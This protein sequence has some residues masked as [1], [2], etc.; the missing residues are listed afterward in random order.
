MSDPADTQ[1]RSHPV[2]AR[3]L[4][5]PVSALM[6][7]VLVVVLGFVS[8]RRIPIMLMPRGISN[9]ELT[10]HASY[11][12]ASP[13]EVLDRVTRPLED[14]I[15]SLPD[16]LQVS[17][18][19]SASSCRIH[20]LCARNADLDLTY[21]ELSDRLEHTKAS[22][23]NEV[24]DLR[25][26]RHNP[27]METPIFWL[28]FN[29]DQ[30]VEDPSGTVD[31]LIQ[32]RLEAVD[33]V[34]QVRVFGIVLE[35]VRLF[36]KPR[37]LRSHGLSLYELV[38]MLRKDNFVLP[39]GGVRDG[40]REYLLRIDA[41]FRSL[42]EIREYPL[43]G[44]LQLQDVADVVVSNAYRDQVSRTNG[45]NSMMAII[46]K[47]SDEN[48]VDV[49]RRVLSQIR[50]LKDDPRLRGFTIEVYF[51]QAN[52]ILSALDNLKGS[53]GWG[54]L[55]AVVILYLFV[56]RAL[57]TLLVALAIPVSLLTALVAI[58][59]SGFSFNL[60]SLAGFTLA[61]GM[62]V[63]N[64]VVVAEN[65]ARC[66][67]GGASLF[68]AAATGAGQV[69]L[70][71]MLSTLTTIIVFTPL[72]FMAE[73]QNTRVLLRE[74][75][76]PITYSLLASLVTAL[77]LLPIAIVQFGGGRVRA[78]PPT[79]D[80]RGGRLIGAYQRLLSF[81][82]RH[83][84]GMVLITLFIVALGLEAAR[85]LEVSFAQG[86][87]DTSLQI[88]VTLP[89]R[90][91]LPEASGVFVKL[92]SFLLSRTADYGFRNLSVNFDRRGGQVYLWSSPE[93][94]QLDKP[95]MARRL[96]QELP[97]IP[98]VRYQIGF[99]R[100]DTQEGSIH[101][102][103]EGPDSENLA[104]IAEDVVREL[105]RLPD[106]AH[107]RSD[108]DAGNDE[109]RVSILS[110]RARRYGISHETL[111]GLISWGVGGQELSG[112]LGGPREIPI[113]IE[114]EKSEAGDL[115][116]VRELDVPVDGRSGSVPLGALARFEFNRSLGSIRRLNGVT[117]LGV[118][119]ETY[120]RNSYRINRAVRDVLSN[121][122]F[123]EGYR[124]R[125]SGGREQ[126]EKGSEEI[127]TG[128]IVG[129][130]FVFLLMG[131]L[132]EAVL[133]PLAVIL[134]I[135]LALA[136][137]NLA[138]FVTGTPLDGMA[139]LAFILL[140]G[141]VVNNGIVLVDRIRQIRDSG[142]PRLEAILTGCGQRLRPVLMTALTTM[143]G[144]LPMAL[145]RIFAAGASS[146][147]NYQSLAIATL[148]GLT[149]STLM[150]VFVVP[151]FYTLFDDLGRI[152]ARLFG[153]TGFGWTETSRGSRLPPP[154]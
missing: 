102:Q 140:A 39:A 74:L 9:S 121:F 127:L 125:D 49:S 117:S 106:L 109:L 30:A 28:G 116:Y 146:G 51:N 55:F 110:E 40:E 88:D 6:A 44:N 86:G 63:D 149:V 2:F 50:R 75:A 64:S 33:G 48:T 41:R 91:T 139:Q 43:K 47:E 37:A 108:L 147:L 134:A 53:M 83:R 15:Q 17:S 90:F 103:L 80:F 4:R 95:E 56:R 137:A 114:Y 107:V 27:E 94:E 67:A 124:W 34:A 38:Q 120:D 23:P 126:F 100:S 96:E 18:D 58:Y 42:K 113:I 5:R 135:P 84:F 112:Y 26:Y 150:T 61:I 136:G 70:A 77:V 29:Y 115:N 111:Q 141:V 46:L 144:L 105:E 8:Y 154:A 131:M 122:P 3:L 25:V 123:P 22:L 36:V 32:S 138:L 66:R 89:R 7:F 45:K 54:A 145:P 60:L 19:S 12:N 71:I 11:P 143:S 119:A 52:L 93:D 133:L 79:G 128:L 20:I 129:V 65:I 132:F 81:S 148:G 72:L 78:S 57:V 13:Q 87:G 153:G 16:I 151:L 104:R 99:D 59:F 69:G 31:D 82:L 24:R 101:L 62:L 85:R 97:E 10:V 76:A 35:S 21:N 92:E 118:Q 14:T 68:E 98:G 142:R 130:I 73:G 1:E 152:L